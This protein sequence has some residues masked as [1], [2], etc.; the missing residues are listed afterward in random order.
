MT[1]QSEIRERAA[2][3]LHQQISE[4]TGFDNGSKF[5]NASE[6]RRYFRVANFKQMLGPQFAVVVNEGAPLND[7]SALN[8]FA[9]A[10]IAHRWHYE[11]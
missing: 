6:V 5:K 3:Q 11:N 1:T 8:D 10:V 2:N 4:Y 7:Q 9:D